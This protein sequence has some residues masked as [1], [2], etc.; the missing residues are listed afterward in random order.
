[1]VNL[2]GLTC[3]ITA[4]EHKAAPKSA[5]KDAATDPPEIASSSSEQYYSH[6]ID[7]AALRFQIGA[8][9]AIAPTG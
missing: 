6:R 9:S 8:L 7:P 1:M 4:H 3:A 5:D 2:F